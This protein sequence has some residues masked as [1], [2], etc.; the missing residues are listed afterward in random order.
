M[1]ALSCRC[2]RCTCRVKVR[3]V[4]Q[5]RGPVTEILADNNIVSYIVIVLVDIDLKFGVPIGF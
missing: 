1:A 3:C 5:R 4:Y 2:T